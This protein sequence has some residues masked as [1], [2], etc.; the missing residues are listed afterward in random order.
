ME[1]HQ[2]PQNIE[3]AIAIIGMAGRFPGA[4]TIEEFWQ[5]ICNGYD[6]ITDFTDQDL[7]EAG[8]APDMLD[9]ANYVRRGGVLENIEYFDATFFDFTPHE[10]MLTDPQHRLFLECSWEALEDAGYD[11]EQYPGPIGVFGGVGLSTYLLFN[12]FAHHA[13]SDATQ[14][15]QLS[16]GNDK[17]YLTTRVSY[18]LN[19]QGPSFNVNTA[20]ST[21][22]VAVHLACQ[23][24]LN[25]ECNMALAGGSSI[26]V[27]QK[28]G[29]LYQEGGVYAR[30][31]SCRAFDSQAEGIVS[32]NGVGVITLK[33]LEDALQDRD[34]IYAII[35]GSA[36][37]NDGSSKVGYTAPSVHGQANAIADA[38]EVAN[39]DPETIQY[40]ETHGTGT[41]VGDPIEIEALRQVFASYTEKK[42]FC[43]IGSVKTN[44]G[45]LGAAAGIAG[46]I[47][48]ALTLK[49]RLI[50][51]SLYFEHPNPQIDF[52][53]S[54][55]YVNTSLSNLQKCAYP[56][57]AAV[58]SFGIGGTNA[59][60]VLEEAPA[61]S[62]LEEH[63]RRPEQQ[64]FLL[65]AKTASALDMAMQQLKAHMLQHPEQSVENIT[66]TLQRGRQRF[67][68]R[69]MFLSESREQAISIMEARDSQ[70]VLTMHNNDKDRP[71]VYLF[72]GGGAQYVHMGSELYQKEE[73][74]QSHIDYCAAILKPILGIDI[75]DILYSSEDIKDHAKEEIKRTSIGLS[76]LFA[77]EY[78]L[79]QC[80]IK[81]GLRPEAMIG[82]SL[83]EYV[84]ACL[85]GVFSLEDALKIVAQ[86]GLLLENLPQ[87]AMISV[88]L[89][90]Q[91]VQSYLQ[92]SVSLA[93][94]NGPNLCVLSG[95]TH[96]I[97]QFSLLFTEQ[98]LENRLIHINAAGHSEMVHSIIDDFIGVVKKY[99]LSAPQIPYVSN[100][101]GTWI[102][103]TEATDPEYWGRHLRSTVRFAEG[104]STLQRSS[105]AVMLEVGPGNTLNTLV[106]LQSAQNTPSQQSQILASLPHPYSEV[107]PLT[108]ILTTL[109]RLWLTGVKIDWPNVQ[110]DG[111]AKRVTLPT[112]PFERQRYWINDPSHTKH[113]QRRISL[114]SLTAYP[115]RI[116]QEQTHAEVH[117]VGTIQPM[118]QG[119]GTPA[120]TAPRNELEESISIAW[121]ELLGRQHI[122]IFDNFFEL[123]GNSLI[124]TQLLS[125]L[126]EAFPVDLPIQAVFTSPTIAEQAEFVE[127]LLLEKLDALTEDEVEHLDS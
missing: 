88:A 43:A 60:I 54:P 10:A 119:L 28:I 57:R 87:G 98:H 124:T 68:W 102:T 42:Q 23:S 89:S 9:N 65:S 96:V 80:W 85:A 35:R 105:N 71:V 55:F 13:M 76:I 30:S 31:G 109:G 1:E 99:P 84:A 5:N 82:H 25:G 73:V 121:R 70:N 63:A 59:H 111:S 24:L 15:L 101:T 97:E 116:A 118:D 51:P 7:I 91:E 18:K 27:P 95:P 75:R 58:S 16:I 44:V 26:A 79:A 21:S 64:L 67:S 81:W 122:S 33:R 77:V 32:G 49:Y 100:V 56:S 72:P 19:L 6:A 39:I 20:C 48:A 74:F 108:H 104:I 37:N 36:I 69:R 114:S 46:L 3:N 38:I 62:H 126:R 41:P 123:G 115:E 125:R 94:I 12:L 110:T 117:E 112:Y 92:A 29:Y 106:K 107:P 50:P 66:Y 90:E 47:K 14:D 120:F 34:S 61:H 83:G 86:R 40:I 11:P 78:A 93:A 103:E 45:H 4:R 127:R 8:V 52:L 22:L 53:T 113:Q 17:D 2:Q